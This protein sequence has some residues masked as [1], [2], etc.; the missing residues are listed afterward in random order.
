[1]AIQRSGRFAIRPRGA[2]DSQQEPEQKEDGPLPGLA[3]D[4]VLA[5]CQLIHSCSRDRFGELRHIPIS[6]C[7][8]QVS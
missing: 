7:T 2:V 3:Q 6:R 4:A 8:T 5:T 1:M